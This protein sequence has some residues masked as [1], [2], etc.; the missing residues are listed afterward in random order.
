MPVPFRV[1]G[2][3]QHHGHW[4]LDVFENGRR[5]KRS[6][7]TYT[8]AVLVAERARKAGNFSSVEITGERSAEI[9]TAKPP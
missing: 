1:H 7:R 5:F 6:F 9:E 8:E 4:R 3:Y 2:P